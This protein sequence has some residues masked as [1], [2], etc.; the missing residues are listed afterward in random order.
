MS[1]KVWARSVLDEYEL[2]ALEDKAVK[3]VEQY[4]HVKLPQAYISILKE[5]NGGYLSTNKFPYSP[6]EN[7]HIEIEFLYGVSSNKN[8]GILQSSYFIKEWGLP[9]NIVLISGSGERWICL[10]YRSVNENPPIIFIDVELELVEQI[11]T[12]FD[13]FIKDLYRDKHNNN[14]QDVVFEDD[15]TEFTY[16]EGE[17]AFSGNNVSK[18]SFAILHFTNTNVDTNWFLVQLNKLASKKN[19]FIVQDA[20]EALYEIVEVKYEIN[21]DEIDNNL[22]QQI[23]DKFKNHFDT[24]VQNYG[25]KIQRMFDK[26][27]P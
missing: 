6:E 12:S 7:E 9:N 25:K 20:A 17:K 4:F 8:E 3:Y 23:I 15:Q 26:K 1:K 11:A 10:D 22:I 27:R 18:I 14:I 5:Q 13:S 24:S 19:E 21:K 16:E 2:E